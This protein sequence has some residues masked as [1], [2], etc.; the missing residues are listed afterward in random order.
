[1][2]D[3]GRRFLRLQTFDEQL[4]DFVGFGLKLV[5]GLL[6]IWRNRA[7]G[8]H[9]DKLS[10]HTWT[11]IAIF[12]DERKSVDSRAANGPHVLRFEFVVPESR[13][14]KEPERGRIV[15]IPLVGGLHPPIPAPRP[16]R[17]SSRSS[18]TILE[19]VPFLME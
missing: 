1:V 2:V 9:H 16:L 6:H 3:D 11:L 8:S 5:D 17:D 14:V 18:A 15:E 10:K 7:G 4:D 12:M 13:V 19:E